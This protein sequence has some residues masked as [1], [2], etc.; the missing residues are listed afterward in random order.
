MDITI[1]SLCWNE[2]VIL[3]YFFYHYKKRFPNARFV[4]Y[5]NMSDDNSIEIIKQNGGEIINFETHN[6]SREDLQMEIRNNCWK[7][8]TTDWVIMCDMDEL[9][10]ID[11]NYLEKTSDSIIKG[12]GY[13]MVDDTYELGNIVFGTRND[14][15]DKCILFNKKFISEINYSNGCHEC[16]PVGK[17]KYN[18]AR[19]ILRHYKYFKLNYVIKRFETLSIRLSSENLHNGWSLHYLQTKNE[20]TNSYNFLEINKRKVPL[21]YYYYCVEN[22]LA[23]HKKISLFNTLLKKIL[24][25]PKGIRRK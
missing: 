3:P 11:E 14:Y 13:E 7:K 15:L 10:E 8:S 5:D 18:K 22:F 23:E 16:F 9:L 20:I 2:E 24:Y 6:E 12:E 4:I 25:L 21:P 19:I 1:Y 17:I